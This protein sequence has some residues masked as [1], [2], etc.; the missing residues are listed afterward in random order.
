MSMAPRLFCHTPGTIEALP[1]NTAHQFAAKHAL[2]HYASGAVFTFIP[3]NAC[4]SL[5]VSLALANGMIGSTDDWTWVHK[6][7]ATFAADLSQ[8]ARASATAVVLRCPYQ[9]LAS[10]FLDK[11]VSRSGE[12]WT[13]YRQSR[14]TLD[15]D[16]LSFRDFVG[17]LE[18][19]GFLKADIHWRPQGDF[20]V[21]DAY[22]RVFGMHQIVE[23]GAFFE[24]VTGQSFVDARPFSNHTTSAFQP[25][26]RGVGADTPLVELISQK[27]QGRLPRA[28]DL[29]DDDLIARVHKLYLKDFRLYR[30]L[31]GKEGLLFS[32]PKRESQT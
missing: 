28:E 1:Q 4:T 16:R 7:N 13:L 23:M 6:N 21:Y 10:V 22:D 32:N 12:L 30:R 2:V 31:L 5:R 25:T 11:I 20:L 8:L 19:P 18:Q 3:K 17:W 24:Q 15:P 27:A 29:Y 14:D 9:R 26:D